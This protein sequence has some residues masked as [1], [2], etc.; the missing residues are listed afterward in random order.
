MSKLILAFSVTGTLARCV[1]PLLR[2]PTLAL[3][4]LTA[5]ADVGFLSDGS[6][7]LWFSSEGSPIRVYEPAVAFKPKGVSSDRGFSGPSHRY[8]GRTSFNERQMAN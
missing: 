7:N 2:I 5:R 4:C 3:P 6:V 1:F 8:R